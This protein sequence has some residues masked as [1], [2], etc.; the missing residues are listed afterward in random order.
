MTASRFET[1]PAQT[2]RNRRG[3]ALCRAQIRPPDTPT[4]PRSRSDELLETAQARALAERRDRRL[5]PIPL[6]RLAGQTLNQIRST[7]R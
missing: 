5:D 4:R 1:S 2:E 6:A 3:I 7:Q